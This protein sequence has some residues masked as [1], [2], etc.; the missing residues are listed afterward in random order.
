MARS[1]DENP[2]CLWAPSQNGLFSEAPQRQSAMAG[3]LVSIWK[4]LPSASATTT[5]PSTTRG[6]LSRILILTS[7]ILALLLGYDEAMMGK[8]TNSRKQPSSSN[9]TDSHLEKL[10]HQSEVWKRSPLT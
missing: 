2:H 7:D 3:L 9:V 10:A 5:G 8:G 4:V 6:P 1:A